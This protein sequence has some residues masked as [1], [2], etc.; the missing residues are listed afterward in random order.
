MTKEE[1]NKHCRPEEYIGKH[2]KK[3][4]HVKRI[5]TAGGPEENFS[6][7]GLDS[8]SRAIQG[9]WAWTVTDMLGERVPDKLVIYR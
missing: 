6:V 4:Y 7:Q 1:Y 9:C 2:T 8:A 5:V 3:F